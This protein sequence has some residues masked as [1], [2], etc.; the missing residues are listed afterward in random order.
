MYSRPWKDLT[1]GGEVFAGRDVYGQSFS[2]LSGFV[3]YGGDERTRDDG[4]L[5]DDSYTGGPNERGSELFVDAG[6]NVNKVRI[7]LEPGIP[8]TST[9]LG[10]D[11]HF[12]VGARRA[13]SAEQRFGRARR[14]G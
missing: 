9:K 4:E 1:V 3:R 5:D 6:V 7:D 10:L 2:R 11:P 8:S 14:T 12:A 13:V